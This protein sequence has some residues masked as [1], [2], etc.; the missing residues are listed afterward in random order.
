MDS[1]N[2]FGRKRLDSI[3][4]YLEFKHVRPELAA[5]IIDFF[6]YKLTSSAVSLQVI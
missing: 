1:R 4:K 6:A 2:A 3:V 5:E